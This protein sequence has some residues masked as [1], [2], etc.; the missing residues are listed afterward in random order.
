MLY[1][2][3]TYR[4]MPVARLDPREPELN[5]NGPDP[6][7]IQYIYINNNILS[8]IRIQ[9]GLYAESAFNLQNLKICAQSLLDPIQ[10][11]TSKSNPNF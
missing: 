6:Y 2:L 3:G 11:R 5:R 7:C 9:Y 4:L 10:I 8:I 1:V